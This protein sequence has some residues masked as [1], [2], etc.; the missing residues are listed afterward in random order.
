MTFIKIYV[1]FQHCGENFC[2]TSAIFAHFPH[3][4]ANFDGTSS[5]FAQFPHCDENFGDKSSKI[6]GLP[7]HPPHLITSKVTIY[8]YGCIYASKDEYCIVYTP[9]LDIVTIV[10][11]RR[12]N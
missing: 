5:N 10:S 6:G 4:G 1:F 3:Y 8:A 11:F 12:L 7:P 2:G 9:V